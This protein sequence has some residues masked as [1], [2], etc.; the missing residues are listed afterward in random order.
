MP[1]EGNFELVE[2]HLPKPRDGEVLVENIYMSVDPYMRGRLNERKS[3]VPPFELG[4]PLE[5]SCVGRIIA[6]R[7][8]RESAGQD[9]FRICMNCLS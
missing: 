3:Y 2:T 9:Q 7:S 6:S 1:V 8:N 5:G 4:K